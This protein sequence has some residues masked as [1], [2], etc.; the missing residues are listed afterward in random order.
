MTSARVL[1]VEDEKDIA[2][3]ISEYLKREG[4]ATGWVSNGK[5]AL[6]ELNNFRWD[7]V[8]LDIMLPSLDGFEVCRRA[9]M[10]GINVPILFLTARGDDVDQVLGL[11][12]GA[13]DYIVKPFSRVALTARVKAHLRRYRDYP[14]GAQF[15]PEEHLKIG[16]LEVDFA[17]CQ[18]WLNDESL[19]LTAKE[20]ELLQY[21]TLNRGRVLTREQIFSQVWG[22]DFFG[23]DNTVTVHIRRLREKIEEDPSAPKLLKTVRGLGYRFGGRG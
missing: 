21:F 20:F 3:A 22:E 19:S 6:E 13:D 8:L 9:R 18:V 5:D 14:G 7:L 11:G 12:L 1:I 10:S 17:A 16:G 23:D 2:D 4:I 15:F